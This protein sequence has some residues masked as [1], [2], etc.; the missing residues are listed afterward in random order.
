MTKIK[1]INS[2]VFNN[3]YIHHLYSW[4]ALY[5]LH[6]SS[7]ALSVYQLISTYLYLLIDI[8]Q[9]TNDEWLALLIGA[10]TYFETN[11]KYHFS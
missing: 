7:V 2:D 1:I 3:F 5:W 9:L 4:S 10:D 11:L 6:L 8:Q